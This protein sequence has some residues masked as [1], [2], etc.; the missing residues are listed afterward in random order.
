MLFFTTCKKGYFSYITFEG[1]V[2]D[3][4]GGNPMPGVHVILDA[5]ETGNADKNATCN[6]SQLQVGDAT[7]DASGYFKIKERRPMNNQFYFVYYSYDHI[8][9][10]ICISESDLLNNHSILYYK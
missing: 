7:S 5:C 3:K 6:C 8:K 4:V 10:L 1:H 9:D 2:Y